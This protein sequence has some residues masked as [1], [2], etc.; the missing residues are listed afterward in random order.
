VTPPLDGRA[1]EV[2][3]PQ[4]RLDVVLDDDRVELASVD[5]V[6]RGGAGVELALLEPD[7]R[8]PAYTSGLTASETAVS[9]AR[10]RRKS[11]FMGGAGHLY[12]SETVGFL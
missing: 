1:V 7:V 11:S 3:L 8:G 6:R 4:P 12:R 2:P 10:I 5:E 9:K